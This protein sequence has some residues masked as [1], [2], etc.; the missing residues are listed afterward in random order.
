M[1]RRSTQGRFKISAKASS[2][3]ALCFLAAVSVLSAC[4]SMSQLT[5]EKQVILQQFQ[6]P[7][8]PFVPGVIGITISG[9]REEAARVLKSHGM[10]MYPE[11]AC[12]SSISRAGIDL[13]SPCSD[14]WMGVTTVLVEPGTEVAVARRLLRDPKILS[15]ERLPADRLI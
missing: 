14:F 13:V 6:N 8:L 1:G 4:T 3:S 15:V 7:D 2:Y 11:R 10:T 9:T 5:R 12:V